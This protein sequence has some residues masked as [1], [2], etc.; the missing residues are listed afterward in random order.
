MNKKQGIIMLSCLLI[1]LIVVVALCQI[2]DK[3]GESNKNDYAGQLEDTLEQEG[4]IIG[5]ESEDSDEVNSDIPNSEQANPNNLNGEAE[6]SKDK[7]EDSNEK[8]QASGD[9]VKDSNEK[10]QTSDEEVK[11]SNEEEPDEESTEKMDGNSIELPFVP[12]TK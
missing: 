5:E 1:V 8:V 11:D 4:I 3:Q 9:K 6:T 12:Y 2:I 10:E 7:A